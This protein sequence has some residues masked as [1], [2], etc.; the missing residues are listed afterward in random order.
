MVGISASIPVE[1]RKKIDQYAKDNK[2]NRSE[3]IRRL[4]RR[5][6]A[7]SAAPTTVH[8]QQR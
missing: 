5:G 2:V 4:L 6:L 1:T 7:A 3:A 8:P